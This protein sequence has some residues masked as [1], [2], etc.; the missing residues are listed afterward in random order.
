[1][2]DLQIGIPDFQM[3]KK[4][5]VHEL[6]NMHGR[7]PFVDVR[8]PAEFEHGHIPGAFNIPLFNNEE[9]VQVGT[10][11]KQV[12]REAAILLGFDLTGGKW[13]GFIREALKDRTR[14]EVGHALLARRDAQRSNGLGPWTS[15]AL[16]Y[17]L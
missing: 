6:L 9:R 11:Y 7:T 14:K 2:K 3:I 15:M 17:A 12:G 10:T 16:R 13:S 5:T 4:V 1:M 8:T